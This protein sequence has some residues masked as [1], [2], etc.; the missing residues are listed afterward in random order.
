MISFRRR[1]DLYQRL[2]DRQKS[3]Q[4]DEDLALWKKGKKKTGPGGRQGPKFWAPPQ[5]GESSSGKKRDMSSVRCFS[6][7]EMGHYAGKCPKKMKNM[8]DVSTTTKEELEFDEQFARECAFPTTLSVVTPSHIKWG[9]RVEDDLLTHISDSEGAQTQFSSTQSSGVN[10]PPGTTSV[11]EL[12]RQ[13]VGAG[14]SEH[15]ILMRRSDRA[16]WRLEPHLT[17]EMGRSGF[18]STSGGSY[19]ARGQVEDLREMSSSR[20]SW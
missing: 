7:R 16:P 19:L 6:C 14:A 13:R 1:L 12:S 3:M 17:M 20:Y 2:L 10:G 15:Q 5:G 4:G 9:D 8:Q 18:G 11:S